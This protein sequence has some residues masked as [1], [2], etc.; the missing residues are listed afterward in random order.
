MAESNL[1]YIEMMRKSVVCLHRY[2]GPVLYLTSNAGNLLSL[3]IFLKKPWRRNVCAFYF[4][5]CVVNNLLYTNTSMLG[6]VFALGFGSQVQHSNV[7]I[8]KLFYYFSYLFAAFLPSAFAC[9]SIDRLLISSESVETRLYSSKRL[10]YFS[11]SICAL[12]W[13]VF[14][15]HTL[16]K[17]GLYRDPL[18]GQTC[19]Y[20]TT[21]FYFEFASYSTLL[22]TFAILL[23]LMVLSI[24]TYR[25]VR[26]IRSAPRR[27]RQQLR[28]MHKRDFQLLYCLYV[29]DIVHTNLALYAGVFYTY[30]AATKY[31]SRTEVHQAVDQLLHA[32]GIFTHQM[33]YCVSFLI[34][35][36]VSKM[37]R[38]EL[39]Q[40][41]RNACS[42][43]TLLRVEADEKHPS[44]VD[45]RVEGDLHPI[46]CGRVVI[47]S[48]E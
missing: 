35:I 18:L 23:L 36:S 45:E 21:G 11:L 5:V 44:G 37:F 25:N 39:K 28:S 8:C 17:V 22:L 26:R 14:Y 41:F 40:L 16:V 38:Q 24:L 7:V 33:V 29:Q 30:Q 42:R 9:A 1:N 47:E 27:H 2:G 34:F 12:F 19:Y 43:F 4:L 31:Q 3:L 48:I 32:L 10:A 13:A 15:V 20:D 6:S 46:N